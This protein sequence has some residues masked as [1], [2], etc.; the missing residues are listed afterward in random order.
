MWCVPELTEDY[1]ACMEDV[2]ALY[3]RP[4]TAAEPV[5]CFDEKPLVLHDEVRLPV[6][7]KPAGRIAKRDS[8]YKRCGT[9]NVFCAVE[10]L[11]GRHFAWPT[12]RR[13]AADFATTLE[14]LVSAYP[15]AKT[16]HI[17]LDNL[18]IHCRK[19]LTDLFGHQKGGYIWSRLTVHH[20]P[21]HGS[22]L[23]Q[24]EIEIGLYSRQCLGR[25]RLASLDKV[26]LETRAW[27]RR[28]N[29]DRLKISWSFDR[30]AA[31]RVFRYA[32]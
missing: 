25:R 24:A 11:A 19:S 21:K 2:L 1:I 26:I 31:R 23:N 16:I 6:P 27:I 12:K 20:T 9:A 13:S 29:R 30:K 8:E 10:P 3:E 17:V 18:N 28:V 5:I 15:W 14:S 7:A 32:H 4:Y 22:W